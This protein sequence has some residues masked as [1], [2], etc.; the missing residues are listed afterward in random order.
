[1]F[2]TTIAVTEGETSSWKP[3]A[4]VDRECFACGPENKYGLRMNFESNGAMLRSRLTLEKQFCGW[5]NLI[6][7]GILSTILDETMSW[8]VIS[9]TGSFMLTKGMQVN[10]LKP[11]RVGMTVTATG[12]ITKRIGDRKVE[13]EA[14]IADQDGRICATSS[15]E[16]VLFGREQFLRMGIMP[17]EEIDAMLANLSR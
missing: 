11:V 14:E 4:K 6:H 5:S 16:F 10:Y 13:V 1:M 8:T 12:Q 7:G 9:L 3:L 15:G 2:E 17:E